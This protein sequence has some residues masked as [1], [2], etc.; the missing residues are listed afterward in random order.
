MV[1]IRPRD[2]VLAESATGTLAGEVALIEL[3]GSEKLVDIRLAGG[4]KL[5]AQVRADYP[6]AAGEHV[7][8]ELPL[9]GLHLFDR[10]SGESLRRQG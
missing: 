10:E 2:V 1:G 6:V 4:Q 8:V 7:G 3:L 5:V 9:A